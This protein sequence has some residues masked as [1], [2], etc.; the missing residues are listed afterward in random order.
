M[1][2]GKIVEWFMTLPWYWKIVISILVIFLLVFTWF[3]WVPFMIFYYTIFAMRYLF[4]HKQWK[5]M[6]AKTK[7]CKLKYVKEQWDKALGKFPDESNW[8]RLNPAYIILGETCLKA[9]TEC[10]EYNAK[11][12]QDAT[13]AEAA[14]NTE[15]AAAARA[16]ANAEVEEDI[17]PEENY[18]GN[19]LIILYIIAISYVIFRLTKSDDTIHVGGGGADGVG[20][21][22]PSP[23][24]TTTPKI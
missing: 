21:P 13:D 11:L 7:R 16:K 20:N 24:S 23:T 22:S 1:F 10:D 6:Q 12:A 3:I 17:E 9:E 4:A 5:K 15:L 8:L 19:G 18:I 2:T 14:K